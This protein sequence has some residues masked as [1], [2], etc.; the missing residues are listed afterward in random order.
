VSGPVTVI[1]CVQTDL[2]LAPVDELPSPGGA[3]FVDH[4][5]MRPGGA[6]ANVALALAELSMPVRLIGC[7]GQDRLGHW[8]LEHLARAE[9]DAHIARV[10][11]GSTGLTVVCEG[12]RRDR[13]FITHLGV[14]ATWSLAMIPED[15]FAATSLL[16]CDYFC[17]PRLQGEAGRELLA[18]ARAAGATTFFDTSWDPAGWPAAT[19]EELRSLLPSVDVFLPNEAE[20]RALAGV[21]GS[22]EEAAR[23]LQ[24]ISGGWVVVK[25]GPRGCFAAGPDGA[26][27][28]APAPA[29]RVGDST[30]AGDAFNAGLIAALAAD[31]SWPEALGQATALASAVV[32][33]RSGERHAFPNRSE[34]LD[35]AER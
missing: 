27:L 4:F 2:L 13:T 28:S 16:F 23:L 6:G 25:L 7:V 19:R 10:R 20:A 18:K 3:L 1:G 15:A 24:S 34:L 35:T 31:A 11:D 22:V 33:R 26:A 32:S 9:L 14:N 30:G 17:A 8:L 29:V 12:P 5:G 21:S